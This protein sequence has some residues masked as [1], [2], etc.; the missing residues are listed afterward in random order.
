[1]TTH[2][3]RET[4][5]AGASGGAHAGRLA[6]RSLLLG[7]AAM[8]LAGCS[9]LSHIF[10]DDDKVPVIGKREPVLGTKND[11]LEPS[12]DERPVD[13]GAPLDNPDWTVAG[14]VANHDSG[15][16]ALGG[17][18][19]LWQVSIGS[20]DSGRA[21]LTAEPVVAD[22]RVYTMDGIGLVSAFD[23]RTGHALWTHATKPKKQRSS[24]MGGGL[25][26]VGGTVYVV[27]GLASALALDAA[28]GKE[29]WSVDIGTPG[30]SAPSVVDGRMFFGTID[31]RLIALDAGSGKTLWSYQ[32]SPSTTIT[33]GQPA[34]AIDGD[35]VVAG[36]GSGDI[37]A[38]RADSGVQIWSD[39]LGAGNGRVSVIDLASVHALPLIKD[40]TVYLISMGDV[41]TAVDLRSGRRIWER[42]VAGKD[43]P[44]IANGWLFILSEEQRLAAIDPATGA[45]RWAVDLPRWKKPNKQKGAISWNGPLLAGGQLHLTSDDGRLI[46][47][48]PGNGKITATVKLSAP[49]ALAPVAAAGVMLVTTRDG[50][51]TA[52]GR[53]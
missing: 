32:A 18:N 7:A 19:R 9:W 27:D 30:R 39:S 43:A 14:R 22:G 36:F 44:V 29:L 34:P 2:R 53:T 35:F 49:A 26:V 25:C 6:R 5:A 45:V 31:E 24:N 42:A 48:D 4:V 41:F 37:V 15:H 40:G 33:L 11:G 3:S 52:Y 23:L 8:P 12:G 38:L 46:A 13:L 28:S 10:D 50:K 20:V 1:M 47:V 16:L 21:A 17:A 51:L